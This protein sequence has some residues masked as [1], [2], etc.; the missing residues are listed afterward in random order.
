MGVMQ[1]SR[2][3]HVMC[4]RLLFG[5][6]YLCDECWAELLKVKD[7][8]PEQITRGDVEKRIR[9]FLETSRGT[10][11]DPVPRDVAFDDIVSR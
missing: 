8:W 3:D 2:C 11:D 6:Y 5:R 1:C 7:S 10:F 4:D 9:D